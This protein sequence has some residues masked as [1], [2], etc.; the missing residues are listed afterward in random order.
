[1]DSRFVASG[2]S[3][4]PNSSPSNK[5]VFARLNFVSICLGVSSKLIL[6]PSFSALLDILLVPSCRLMILAPTGGMYGSGMVKTL[7]PLPPL[8]FHLRPP[9]LSLILEAMSLVSSMCCFWSSPTGTRSALYS[10]MSAAIRVGYVNS[11]VDTLSLL[12]LFTSSSSFSSSST[13]LSFRDFSLYWI[14][15][16]SHPIGVA[17]WSSHVSSVCALTWDCTKMVAL[18]GSTPLAR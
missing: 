3:G 12:F 14:M 16:S 6:D 2:L 9:N 17:H 4:F 18:L 15:R 13:L 5:S 7:P 11:P 8:F 10:S 1:M